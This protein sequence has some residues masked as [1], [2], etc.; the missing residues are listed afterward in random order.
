MMS[1][2]ASLWIALLLTQGG[3]GDL[4]TQ[5]RAAL[6]QGRLEDAARLTARILALEPRHTEALYLKGTIL[7]ASGRLAEA[8]QVLQQAVD[9]QPDA[10]PAVIGLAE[11]RSRLG[12]AD[13]A[14]Q[15]FERGL[16]ARPGEPV[17]LFQLAQLLA[18]RQDFKGALERLRAIPQDRYPPDYF[19]VLGRTLVSAGD[20]A[21][22]QTAYQQ[23]L[24]LHPNSVKTLQTLSAIALKRGIK[25]EAWDYI[26]RARKLAPNSA[27]VVFAFAGVSLENYLVSEAIMALRL[28]LLREPDNPDYLLMLGNSVLESATEF[29]R[30]V[31]YFSRYV[32]LRPDDALGHMMLGYGH[33]V[34]RDYD[35][36]EAELRKTLEIQPDFLEAEY[37]LAM[38]DYHANRDDAAVARLEALL[39][40]R[41]DHHRAHTTLGKIFLRQRRFG[42]AVEHLQ[43][44]VKLTGGSSDLHFNLSRAFTQLG[45][46]GEAE[47]QLALYQQFKAEEEKREQ[48]GRRLRFQ[49]LREQQ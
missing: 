44:A 7:A 19:E 26:A 1:L 38:V 4:L 34:N 45:D 49:E 33:Y 37:Y 36:A 23:Y 40:R 25:N 47:R 30:A 35:K 32:E 27:Q 10:V 14:V 13:L 11:V 15:T 21:G 28:L 46:R 12:K 31:D 2:P 43:R 8:E 3:S 5:A 17:L 48:E 24:Q 39:K 18:K 41:P 16:V 42:E 29:S 6:D 9:L 20:L 22:A